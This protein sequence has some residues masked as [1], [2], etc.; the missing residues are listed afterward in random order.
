MSQTSQWNAGGWWHLF[1]CLFSALVESNDFP[2]PTSSPVKCTAQDRYKNIYM[3]TY[4][5]S[6]LSKMAAQVLDWMKKIKAW[7][8][9]QILTHTHNRFTQLY[10]VHLTDIKSS[11]IVKNRYFVSVHLLLGVY[12]RTSKRH[13]IPY[14]HRSV[15]VITD[16][17]VGLTCNAEVPGSNL[18]SGQFCKYLLGAHRRADRRTEKIIT[19]YPCQFT[20]FTWRI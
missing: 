7:I 3:T 15:V 4:R 16:W 8:K 14:G 13:Y 11:T 18:E 12:L 1:V 9:I 20:P 2:H 19:L 17:R 6:L 5:H 10:S